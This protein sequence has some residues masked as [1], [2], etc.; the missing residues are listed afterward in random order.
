MWAAKAGKYDTVHILLDNGADVMA[1]YLDG[2]TITKLTLDAGH[3]ELAQS[4]IHCYPDLIVTDPRL[5]KGAV[6]LREQFA[7]T[8][9]N[10]KG[11]YY[12]A[13]SLATL[14]QSKVAMFLTST[15]SIFS[16]ITLAIFH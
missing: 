13:S 10:I 6:W 9:T 3:T 12:I 11:P 8:S 15:G 5:L 1:R 14:G 16:F 7:I 4:I 2:N